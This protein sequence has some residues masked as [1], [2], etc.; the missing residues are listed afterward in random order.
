LAEFNR[1]MKAGEFAQ[2]CAGAALAAK[3]KGNK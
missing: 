1:R 3:K 2:E